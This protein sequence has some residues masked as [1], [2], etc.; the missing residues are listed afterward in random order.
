MDIHDWCKTFLHE[1]PTTYHKFFTMGDVYWIF[2]GLDA[3]VKQL[4][5]NIAYPLNPFNI[6]FS[7]VTLLVVKT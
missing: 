6:V 3:S 4:Y 7:T 2:I 1:H 5:T